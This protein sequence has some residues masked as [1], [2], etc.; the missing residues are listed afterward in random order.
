MGAAFVLAADRVA[1]LQIVDA[2]GEVGEAAA[3]LPGEVTPGA[4]DGDDRPLWVQNG[5]VRGKRIHRGLGETLGVG[6]GIVGQTPVGDVL[7][8]AGKP[9][10]I[11]VVIANQLAALVDIA[12]RAI[13]TDDA[14]LPIEGDLTTQRRLLL[15]E[16]C[17]QILRV[18]EG[19]EGIKGTIELLGRRAE[20]LMDLVGPDQSPCRNVQLP[21]PEMGDALGL[22]QDALLRAKSLLELAAVGQIHVDGEILHRL[23]GN[24]NR[25]VSGEDRQARA[26]L[27]AERDFQIGNDCP[28]PLGLLELLSVA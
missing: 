20:D 22:C 23:A 19:G 5:D 12:N 16:K 24:L 4:V 2:L 26:I 14:M 25:S 21:A 27:A 8:R 15:E 3:I 13:R 10:G 18:D 7:D 11:A 1:D 6:T 28:F 17:L 9:N